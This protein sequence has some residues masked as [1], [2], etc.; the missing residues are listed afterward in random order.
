MLTAK[1]TNEVD[2][3]SLYA[4][5]IKKGD[6]PSLLDIVIRKKTRRNN[7]KW[8]DVGNEMTQPQHWIR[9]SR[10]CCICC[11]E[12]DERLLWRQL[13]NVVVF[14][15]TFPRMTNVNTASNEAGAWFFKPFTSWHL[16]NDYYAKITPWHQSFSRWRQLTQ[17]IK[18]VAHI[19]H[20]WLQSFSLTV[21]PS[22][23]RSIFSQMTS[24]WWYLKFYD[25][26]KI[27]K[28]WNQA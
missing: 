4:G 2:T 25:Y 11:D 5:R 3:G 9:F 23:F 28:L 1:V 19:R 6:W 15:R 24:L 18:I 7:K 10:W 20:T 22:H 12:L 21:L 27:T 13:C 8:H 14:R 26:L 16:P 17:D